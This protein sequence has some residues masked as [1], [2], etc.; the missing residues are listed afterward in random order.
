[1][2]GADQHASVNA[3]LAE[4]VAWAT[5]GVFLEGLW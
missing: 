3:I 1:M 4:A 5:R 2:L